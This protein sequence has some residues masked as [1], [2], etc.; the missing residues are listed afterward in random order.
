M[1]IFD[2]IRGCPREVSSRKPKNTM[3]LEYAENSLFL[4]KAW[5]GG[6]TNLIGLLWFQSV[7]SLCLTEEFQGHQSWLR[8]LK[9]RAHPVCQSKLCVVS[10]FTLV[11]VIVKITGN[12]SEV[13]KVRS[14]CWIWSAGSFNICLEATEHVLGFCTKALETVI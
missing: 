4:D 6:L 1:L 5:H 7:A 2:G 10:L 3:H 12:Y 13:C 8:P 14:A 9:I 11:T